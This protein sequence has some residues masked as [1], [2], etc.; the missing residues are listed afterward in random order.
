VN[1]RIALIDIL[2]AERLEKHKSMYDYV[3][4]IMST[5]QKLDIDEGLDNYL[6]AVMMLRGLPE[7]YKPMK[8]ALEHST[9]DIISESIRVKLLQEDLRNVLKVYMGDFTIF[10]EEKEAQGG[11]Q[12]GLATGYKKKFWCYW[13]GKK[14]RIKSEC[15]IKRQARKFKFQG[16]ERD[17]SG[18]SSTKDW[19]LLFVLGAAAFSSKE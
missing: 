9:C 12:K 2:L 16:S 8:M 1:Q 14:G 7:E 6:V 18:S 17:I 11:S 10:A 13:C 5:V 3:T 4:A 19:Y 15:P